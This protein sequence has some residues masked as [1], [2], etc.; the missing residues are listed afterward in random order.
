MLQNR[1]KS[2]EDLLCYEEK[3]QG[4]NVPFGWTMVWVMVNHAVKYTI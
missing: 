3:R 2:R 4:R 1:V